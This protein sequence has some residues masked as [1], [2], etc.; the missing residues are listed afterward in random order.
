MTQLHE[1]K[2]DNFFQSWT[3]YRKIVAANNMFHEQIY[4]DVK[5]LLQQQ[6][7]DFSLLDL[8]CGDAACLAPVLRDVAINAYTGVDLSAPALGLAAENLSALSCP[9][10]LE[11]NDLLSFMQQQQHQ[12]DV[13]FSSFALHHLSHALKAQFFQAARQSLAT[14]GVLLLIDTFREPNEALPNY[15]SAYCKWINN[16]WIGVSAEEKALACQHIIDNDIPETLADTEQ[17]AE[18]AGFAQCQEISHYRWHKVL[19]LSN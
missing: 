19:L 13:I 6:T 17:L 18:Q 11:L 16:D 12:Y 10:Q 15:L 3:I 5:Q 1:P 8:G 4:T 7:D 9:I 14:H 2:Q